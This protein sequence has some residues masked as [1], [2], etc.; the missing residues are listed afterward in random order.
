MDTSKLTIIVLNWN[1]KQATLGCVDSLQ[2]ADL[3]G[4]SLLVVDNGSRDGSVDALRA[5]FPELRVL[6]LPQNVGYAGGN[7]AGIRAAME[8]GAESVL[9]LNNDTE[10]AKDFLLP[11]TWAM[12]SHPMVAGVCSAIHR[13]DHPEMLDVAYCLTRFGQRD[14]VQ[15]IGVNAL[16]GKGFEERREIEIA[17]GCSLLLRTDVLRQVGLLDERYFAYHEDVDWCLRAHKLGYRF[18]YEPLS[19]VFHRP[20][21]STTRLQDPAAAVSY[22]KSAADLPN[23]EALPW[24]PIRTYL[25]A[26]NMVRLLRTYA[27]PQERRAFVLSCLYEIPLEMLAILYDREG[28]MRLGRWSYGDAARLVVGQ[29]PWTLPRRVWDATQSGRFTQLRYQLRGFWD[30]VRDRPLPLQWLGLR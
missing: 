28:W 7:N 25:G 4:A 10:V 15:I 14:A 3:H 30:G 2:R 22:T 18:L 11:L 8:T 21:S 6:P 20:S 1:N 19:R 23:A 13:H 26:R 16:P 17:I 27:T 9:L 29:Q 5:R 12:D 24:N